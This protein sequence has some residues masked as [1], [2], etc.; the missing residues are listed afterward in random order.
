[1]KNLHTQSTR[2]AKPCRP[3]TAP[4]K[5]GVSAAVRNTLT[6]C[7]TGHSSRKAGRIHFNCE[8]TWW[9]R[10][11][12][13]KRGLAWRWNTTWRSGRQSAQ[14]SDSLAN[15]QARYAGRVHRRSSPR[16]YTQSVYETYGAEERTRTSTSLR[17]HEPESCASANSATSAQEEWGGILVALHPVKAGSG[18]KRL[19]RELLSAVQRDRQHEPLHRQ[20]APRPVDQTL[21]IETG[22]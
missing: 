18:R 19:R 13:F 15:T 11:A 2:S 17:T 6:S 21:R 20:S 3:R 5:R 22:Q 14:L 16:R 12:R 9:L 7:E 10:D 8:R 1:M 4:A